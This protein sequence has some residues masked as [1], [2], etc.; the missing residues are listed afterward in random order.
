MQRYMIILACLL[1]VRVQNLMQLGGRADFYVL[2]FG[3]VNLT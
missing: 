3:V 1:G 2:L